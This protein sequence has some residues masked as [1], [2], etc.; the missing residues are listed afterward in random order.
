LST[1]VTNERRVRASSNA[2]RA[3]R[4]I[5]AGEYSHVS[6]A[7]PS[8]RRP[9]AAE[10]EPAD[11]LADDQ[12]VDAVAPR[13][14][15]IRVDVELAPKTDQA[16]LGAHR[17]AVELREAGRAEEDGVRG[18]AGGQRFRGQRVAVLVDGAAAE[19]MLLDPDVDRQ[20]I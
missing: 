18:P 16:L 7:D 19:R 12:Q 3:I 11:E 20:R 6:K 1:E 15:K 5:S 4:S 10:V 9:L 2:R 13:G 17:C 8:A 14:A